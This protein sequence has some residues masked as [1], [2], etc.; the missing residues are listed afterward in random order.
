[1]PKGRHITHPYNTRAA[2]IERSITSDVGSD[3]KRARFDFKYQKK[4]NRASEMSSDE[5]SMYSSKTST[6]SD[7]GQSIIKQIFC[8]TSES[9]F[10]SFSEAETLDTSQSYDISTSSK[11]SSNLDNVRS[12]SLFPA[13]TKEPMKF[14]SSS[15]N[16]L[17]N[18]TSSEENSD[19]KTVSLQRKLKANAAH[20]DTKGDGNCFFHAVFGDVNSSSLYETD[21]AQAMRQEWCKFLGKF[22]S[23]EDELMPK[24]LKEALLLIFQEVFKEVKPEEHISDCIYKEYLAKIA[25]QSYHV[26]VNEIVILASLANIKIKLHIEGQS[27]HDIEPNEKLLSKNYKRNDEIWGK[28]K[29]VEIRHNGINHF[30]YSKS[31]VEQ[32]SLKDIGNSLIRERNLITPKSPGKENRKRSRE[33]ELDSPTE[34]ANQQS[35]SSSK[36]ARFEP[37]VSDKEIAPQNYFTQT[38]TPSENLESLKDLEINESSIKRVNESPR[39][40][41]YVKNA[42]EEKYLILLQDRKMIQELTYY[43]I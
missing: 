6:S 31:S 28:R 27:S 39:V 5:E 32:P 14:G 2:A 7:S 9:S 22:K 36:R 8:S 26:Y 12:R 24:E 34:E 23:L 18:E 25:E 41:S 42:G 38:S 3:R 35:H 43:S 15:G 40:A 11:N 16:D 17:D 30:S 13:G 37:K 19:N 4:I 20:F 1:M 10:E 29:Q 33:I 21:K